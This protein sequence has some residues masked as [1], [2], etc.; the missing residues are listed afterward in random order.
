M[1]KTSDG[2]V[3]PIRFLVCSGLLLYHQAFFSYLPLATAS[4]TVSLSR[5]VGNPGDRRINLPN[6]LLRFLG[7][8][9]I[10]SP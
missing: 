4:L 7:A 5:S 2:R 8:L 10:I 1:I 3:V 6:K 9:E